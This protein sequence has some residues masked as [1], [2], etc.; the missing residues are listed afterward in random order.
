MFPHDNS[1]SL[2]FYTTCSLKRLITCKSDYSVQTVII[3]GN[4]CILWPNHVLNDFSMLTLALFTLFRHEFLISYSVL[5][6]VCILRPIRPVTMNKTAH[7]I[8]GGKCR[9]TE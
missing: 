2:H 8:V 6:R 9:G 1:V 3:I 4:T 7:N 5:F